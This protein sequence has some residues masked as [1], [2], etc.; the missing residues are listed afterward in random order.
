MVHLQLPTRITH[1][2]Y[3]VMHARILGSAAADLELDYLEGFLGFATAADLELDNL[4]LLQNLLALDANSAAEV[5]NLQ[6]LA[7]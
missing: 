3:L 4:E 5:E 2:Q 6:L 7:N 1:H